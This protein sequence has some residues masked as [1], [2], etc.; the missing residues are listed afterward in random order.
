MIVYVCRCIL[1][2]ENIGLY[3]SEALARAYVTCKWLFFFCRY[4]WGA[5]P[6]HAKKLATLLLRIGVICTGWRGGGGCIDV[7]LQAHRWSWQYQGMHLDATDQKL[8]GERYLF[9]G[10]SKFSQIFTFALE[11]FSYLPRQSNGLNGG[12]PPFNK[13]YSS[14]NTDKQK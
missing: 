6:P 13:I 14:T 4:I 12:S 11:Y 3:D 9:I 1:R 2:P 5:P 8:W 10:S 7:S